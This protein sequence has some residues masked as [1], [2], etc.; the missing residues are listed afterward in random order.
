MYCRSC[1]SNC[2]NLAPDSTSQS[3]RGQPVVKST[4]CDECELKSRSYMPMSGNRQYFKC[5]FNHT[6]RSRRSQICGLF[7]CRILRVSLETIH[8]QISNEK[9]SKIQHEFISSVRLIYKKIHKQ[10]L[11]F[12]CN[13]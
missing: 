2:F 1:L 12:F 4:L 9:L 5:G 10:K 8:M 13:A 6:P 3:Y 11:R 7:Q